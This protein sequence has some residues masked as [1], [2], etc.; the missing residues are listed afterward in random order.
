MFVKFTL[1]GPSDF[2][3][4]ECSVWLLY[5]CIVKITSCVVQIRTVIIRSNNNNYIRPND[6]ISFYDI[7]SH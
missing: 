7:N 3:R 2:V 1:I 4:E 6:N 5:V